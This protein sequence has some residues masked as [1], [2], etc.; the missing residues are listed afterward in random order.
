MADFS[1]PTVCR[2]CPWTLLRKSLTT[3]VGLPEPTISCFPD[4][5]WQC[6]QKAGSFDGFVD[7]A[8]PVFDGVSRAQIG[9]LGISA[10]AILA[11]DA[12]FPVNVIGQIVG[13][14][15]QV[16]RLLVP[17]F[18]RAVTLNAHVLVHGD[19]RRLGGGCFLRR[20]GWRVFPAATRLAGVSCGVSCGGVPAGVGFTAPRRTR[21]SHAERH[22][23]GCF[24]GDYSLPVGP[25]LAA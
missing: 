8:E 12:L 17:N 11:E 7:L 2:C 24:T 23:A 1:S 4:S 15:E 19:L 21:T 25:P 18:L 16:L 5:A 6:P 22:V 3:V 13:A 20:L 9:R 14:D 10:V